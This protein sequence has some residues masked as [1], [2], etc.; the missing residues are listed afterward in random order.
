MKL[1]EFV[2]RCTSVTTLCGSTC[3]NS[4]K[5]RCIYIVTHF[6]MASHVETYSASRGLLLKCSYYIISSVI[7]TYQAEQMQNSKIQVLSTD[8]FL[9][10]ILFGAGRM[11]VFIYMCVSV[12]VELCIYIYIYYLSSYINSPSGWRSPVSSA[13]APPSTSSTSFRTIICLEVS[14]SSETRGENHGSHPVTNIAFGDGWNMMRSY[15]F[16]FHLWWYWTSITVYQFQMV[17]FPVNMNM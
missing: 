15:S 14:F 13:S 10:S 8:H 16:I 11:Y 4:S 6:L 12:C 9:K 2:N 1:I 3:L 17:A 7:Q 5:Y